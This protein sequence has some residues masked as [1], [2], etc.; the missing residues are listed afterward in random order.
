MIGV[1]CKY[2]MKFTHIQQVFF[3]GLLLVT[4]GV[5][6]WMLG[7]YLL[8]V[9]WGA[10]IAIIFYPIHTQIERWLGGRATVAA[11]ATLTAVILAVLIPLTIV[12]GLIVQD[13]I[14][15]YQRISQNETFE[16]TSLLSRTETA[17]AF[18]EPYGISQD[19]VF[20]R[21]REWTATA[22]Q[23]VSSSLL[24]ASQMTLS[25]F[26][27]IGV[28]IYLLFFFFRDGPKLVHT[29]LFYLPM[30]QTYKQRL[31]HRF[32]DT[33]RAVV[34]GTVTVAVL[35][36]TI[37][38][39]TF[40]QTGMTSPVLW[41]VVIAMLSLIP[42]LG[43][44]LVWLPAGIILIATGSLWSG[45]IIL[46]VG[47]LLISVIDE[48]LRPILVGRGS[49]IPD[50]IILLATIGGLASFGISGF[51]IGPIV[52]AFFL[53]LWTIFGERYQKELTAKPSRNA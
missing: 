26:I 30:E 23:A 52:A 33:A 12:G 3:F 19:V 18:L 49:K 34:K 42:A 46:I 7:S 38:G 37:I 1:Y 20:E 8:P 6:L 31:L 25:L 35:Q 16:G 41:G 11:L 9:L 17:I 28:M 36:G 51:V 43:P 44:A 5:F 39:I 22:T 50:A 45:I 53:S 21:I 48:F 47:V 40:W 4:S 13:S 29:L 27:Y 32:T 10:I 15:L 24:T 14:E 2:N